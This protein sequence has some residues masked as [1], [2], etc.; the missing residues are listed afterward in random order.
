MNPTSTILSFFTTLACAALTAALPLNA[1][2]SERNEHKSLPATSGGTLIFTT[3]AGAIDIKTHDQDQVTYDAVLKPGNGWFGRSSSELID[4][5]VFDYENSGADVKI[6]MK[7]KDGKQ[8]RGV[9]LNA[10]HT[11]VVP[12]K[13]NLEVRTAGGSIS[14][15]DITGNVAAHTSGGNLK[16]GKVKGEIK[17]HTSGGSI[18][19]EDVKGNADVE[20]SGG[21]IKVGNV[22]GNVSAHTSGG[23]IQVGAVS[24][25]MKGHTSGGSIRAELA[26]QIEQPLELNTSGGSISLTVPNDFKADLNA[27]TSGG[28]V[29]CDLPVEGAVKRSSVNGKLNGGGPKVSLST[30]GGSIK[31]AKR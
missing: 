6:A 12:A 5:I 29:N 3:F 1:A 15:A 4:Q 25:A 26:G 19:L 2:E 17:A 20:T 16:F 18:S 9:S 10:R 21:S 14:V 7:W 31:V 23:S 30:S 28:N 24:G 13:Y 11:L 8:P 22:E 27:S